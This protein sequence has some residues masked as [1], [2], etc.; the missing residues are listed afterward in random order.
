MI[1]PVKRAECAGAKW[2]ADS[3]SLCQIALRSERRRNKLSAVLKLILDR[4][5][6]N[7]GYRESSANAFV[8]SR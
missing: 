8:C 6:I 1:A 5:L 4:A 7:H 3:F 2:D